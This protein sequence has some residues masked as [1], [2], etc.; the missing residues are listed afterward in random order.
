MS[1]NEDR[2]SRTL[3]AMAWERAKGE[4]RSMAQT[5]WDCREKFEKFDEE[6]ESFIKHIEGEGIHE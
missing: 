5:Y 3:R 2:V 4:L 6:V 1:N